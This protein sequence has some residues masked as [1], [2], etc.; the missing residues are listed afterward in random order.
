MMET[1]RQK[2]LA[3]TDYERFEY[4]A[5]RYLQLLL[6]AITLFAMVLVTIDLVRD[7]GL[8]DRRTRGAEYHARWAALHRARR[9]AQR[10]H[11]ETGCR[12]ACR[13]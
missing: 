3:L 4:L 12:A 8:G 10:C 7:F 6:A 5:L 1:I 9:D 2:L 11:L 13:L